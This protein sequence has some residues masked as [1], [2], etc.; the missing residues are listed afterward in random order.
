M[1]V[2]FTILLVILLFQSSFGQMTPAPD[3]FATPL[4]LSFSTSVLN[5]TSVVFNPIFQKYYT[6]RAGNPLF[7]LE[8]FS[9]TGTPIYQTTA[10]LDTRGMWWNPITSQVERN[11]YASGG[12]ATVNLTTSGFAQNSYSSIFPG[13][14]QPNAQSVG[15]FDYKNNRVLYY[16]GGNQIYFYDR[17]SG[18]PS[19]ALS[20]GG[21][22][23]TNLNLN[24]V[25]YT[26]QSGYEIGLLNYSTKRVLLFNINTGEYAGYSQ[27]PSNAPAFNQ[28]R[29]SYANDMVW[30]FN[31]SNSMWY[32]Y[33]IWSLILPNAHLDFEA[34]LRQDETIEL[35]WKMQEQPDNITGFSLERA[36]S[37]EAFSEIDEQTPNLSG[38]YLFMDNEQKEGK[39]EYRIRINYMNGQSSFSEIKT[40]TRASLSSDF[41]VSVFPNPASS[42]I[43]LTFG[44][45]QSEMEKYILFNSEGQD[46]MEI[47][48]KDKTVLKVDISA[49]SP[50]IYYLKSG[51]KSQ[52]IIKE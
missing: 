6:V 51:V 50:G 22:T 15:A 3:A 35:T 46:V 49:L 39:V 47:H 36:Y 25:I 23:F 32:S 19:G 13:Q 31:A 21:T 41:W 11:Q 38:E 43:N 17:S 26:G 52:K 8:S 5:S 44:Q 9:Q 28:F 12:W 34:A 33:Y 40:L 20:L 4:T 24:S 18:L 16:N 30:L 1:K 27:L 14:L 7:P 29:F 10:G 42:E 37:G 48:S 2:F 45:S